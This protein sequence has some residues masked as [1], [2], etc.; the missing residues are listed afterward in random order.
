MRSPVNIVSTRVTSY[1]P[2]LWSNGEAGDRYVESRDGATD[3]AHSP[4]TDA[5]HSSRVCT[6]VL[7]PL[8]ILLWIRDTS[9]WKANRNEEFGS[10][11]SGS[12]RFV[13]FQNDL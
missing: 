10:I 8:W 11:C 7:V 2:W 9:E 6:R 1:C 12:D 4:L 3:D 5:T 13:V